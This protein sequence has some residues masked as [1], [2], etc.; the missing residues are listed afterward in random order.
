M[1]ARFFCPAKLAPLA[2][3]VQRLH[4]KISRATLLASAA[5]LALASSGPSAAADATVVAITVA[6][7]RMAVAAGPIA[8]DGPAAVRVS[9]AAAL[10]AHGI[11]HGMKDARLVPA[12]ARS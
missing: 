2:S 12:R 9:N 11:T 4:A 1:M 10:A 3:A 8:G 6:D 7:A 5:I